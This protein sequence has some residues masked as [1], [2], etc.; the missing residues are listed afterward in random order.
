[1]LMRLGHGRAA[2]GDLHLALVSGY[3]EENRHKLEKR[4]EE[5][6]ATAARE[7][8]EEVEVEEEV[9]ER[10]SL[11]PAYTSALELRYHPVRPRQAR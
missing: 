8:P 10:N 11:V 4:R 1:M 2:L 9:G 6:L 7:A 3:P 5:C